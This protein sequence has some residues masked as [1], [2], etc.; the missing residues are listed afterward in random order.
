[1]GYFRMDVHV[2]QDVE[3]E[4]D[5]EEVLGQ[6]DSG[7]VIDYVCSNIDT[8]EVIGRMDVEDVLNALDRDEV[9]DYVINRRPHLAGLLRK[10]ADRLD[11]Q[12]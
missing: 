10:I 5:T 8:S 7:D 2:D 3:V 1:M 9:V 6:M 4:L 12:A 11:Q